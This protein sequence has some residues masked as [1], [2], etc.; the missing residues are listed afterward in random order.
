QF[1]PDI[2]KAFLEIIRLLQIK[3]SFLIINRYPAIGSKWW[4]IAKIK[5][6]EEYIAKLEKAG[7]GDIIVDFGFKKGWIIIKATKI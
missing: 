7:F 1:W 2:D 3:G 5:N 6:D 4:K